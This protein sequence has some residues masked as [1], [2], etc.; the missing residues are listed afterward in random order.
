MCPWHAFMIVW[1][2]TVESL[3]MAEVR[4]VDSVLGYMCVCKGMGCYNCLLEVLETVRFCVRSSYALF[5]FSFGD[6][7]ALGVDLTP[8]ARGAMTI[9]A[10]RRSS[11]FRAFSRSWRMGVLDRVCAWVV[12]FVGFAIMVAEVLVTLVVSWEVC[13]RSTITGLC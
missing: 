7:S 12:E 6:C 13:V 11:M 10:T 2:H 4:W 1:C 5:K 8:V 9:G 3:L